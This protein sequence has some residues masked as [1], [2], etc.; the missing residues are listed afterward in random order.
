MESSELGRPRKLVR[1]RVNGRDHRAKNRASA[2][3]AKPR[4]ISITKHG[5]YSRELLRAALDM[6]TGIGKWDAERQAGL[7]AHLGGDATVL[8]QELIHQES[9]LAIMARIAW[10]EIQRS[11]AL[12]QD[13]LSASAEAYVRIVREQR[14]VIQALGTQRRTQPVPDLHSYL[15]STHAGES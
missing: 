14:S 15:S 12:S 7:L 9:R 1:K 2:K 10:A 4:K 11:G 13:G 5:L 3:N 6:R 8:E